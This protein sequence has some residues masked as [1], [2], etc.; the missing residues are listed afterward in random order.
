MTATGE[1]VFNPRHTLHQR[2]V[3]LTASVPAH[4]A[5]HLVRRRLG[6]QRRKHLR[7]AHGTIKFGRRSEQHLEFLKYPNEGPRYA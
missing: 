3:R 6:I 4:N 1:S 7:K 2:R 5:N